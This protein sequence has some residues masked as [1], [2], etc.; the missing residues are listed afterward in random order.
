MLIIWKQVETYFHEF[1]HVMHDICAQV[2]FAM[3][4]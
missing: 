3:F 1:G 2:D 4:R